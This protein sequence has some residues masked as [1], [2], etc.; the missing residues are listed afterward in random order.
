MPPPFVFSVPYTFYYAQLETQCIAFLQ[1]PHYFE[2]ICGS[3]RIAPVSAG[4]TLIA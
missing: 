4:L 1:S 2:Y 3:V